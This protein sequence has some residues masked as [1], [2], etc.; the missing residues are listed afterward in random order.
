MR[1]KILTLLPMVGG[2]LAAPTS[3]ATLPEQLAADIAASTVQ[4]NPTEH[5]ALAAPGLSA[6][7][8]LPADAEAYAVISAEQVGLLK[9]QL[10]GTS[11]GDEHFDALQSAAIAIGKGSSE[12]LSRLASLFLLVKHESSNLSLLLD[13]KDAASASSLRVP[14][15]SDDGE[16]DT[17]SM[18]GEQAA[19]TTMAEKVID[20]VYTN[21][22]RALNR[23]ISALLEET[24]V[25]PVY[26]AITTATEQEQEAIYARILKEMAKNSKENEAANVEGFEGYKTRPKA[27]QL[28]KLARR[29][30][31]APENREF[32]L[33]AKK[34]GKG[35]VVVFCENPAEI[36]LAESPEKS[37]LT[38]DKLQAAEAHLPSLICAG[39]AS[40]ESIRAL[41]PMA[42]DSYTYLAEKAA[43]IFAELAGQDEPNKAVYEAAA[44]AAL[45]MGKWKL[46]IPYEANTKPLSFTTWKHG[47]DVLAEVV[48]DSVGMRYQ[49]GK[50]LSPELATAEST[51]LYVETT[52]YTPTTSLP[53]GIVEDSLCVTKGVALTISEQDKDSTAEI[54]QKIEQCQP[55][56][57]R[58][59]ANAR[60]LNTLLTAPAMFTLATPDANAAPNM[61]GQKLPRLAAA[62]TVTDRAGLTAV[63]NDTLTIV[64]D[65]AVKQGIDPKE[66]EL[67][68]ASLPIA[69]RQMPN[70]VT[71]HVLFHPLLS[72][73]GLEP[74]IALTD[75]AMVLGVQTPF[76]TTLAASRSGSGIPFEGAVIAV[77]FPQMEQLARDV[78]HSL[79]NV[80]DD[81]DEMLDEGQTSG[82]PQH[83]L[84]AGLAHLS[85]V[86]RG[87]Y[88]V[89][90]IENGHAILRVKLQ[91][92]Q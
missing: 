86:L 31:K 61:M 11:A 42:N 66:A 78:Q 76:T 91:A 79:S 53:E 34:H 70:G 85:K 52:P 33:L 29:G 17:E 28:R 23:R 73:A 92:Q 74:Q 82:R 10:C 65:I 37:L 41:Q 59:I 22:K 6:L 54:I 68:L 44:A 72:M 64:R 20:S 32:Y 47:N 46:S 38:T 8:L 16:E 49:P 4:V 60:K 48:C 88:A 80:M 19:P 14:S 63:W 81:E 83:P 12:T 3:A 71:N 58:L 7:G 18:T 35:I 51:I 84:V 75:T 1:K 36:C 39:W 13:W 2:L 57:N 55:E 5:T 89:S 21:A 56:L 43:E 45:R 26:L 24:H 62:F 40:A 30:I 67:S 15:I 87:L 9:K 77:Q 25:A 27:S 50:L 69:S 90:T